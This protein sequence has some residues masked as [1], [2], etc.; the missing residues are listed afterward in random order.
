MLSEKKKVIHSLVFPLFFLIILWLIK[1]V[2]Y[3]LD[4]SFANLGVYP[5]KI[6]GLIGII[7]APLIHS[8]FSH[9]ISNS[10]PILLLSF[11]L[12]YFYRKVAYRVFFLIYFISGLWVWVSARPSFHIGASGIVYG[13]AAFLLLSGILRRN[14]NLMGLSLLIIFLY[15][16]LIWGIFPME[17]KI[18]WESHLMGMIAGIVLAI[19][20]KKEGPQRKRFDWED[21]NEE[22]ENSTQVKNN[23]FNSNNTF[24]IEIEY[25]I[26]ENDN[27]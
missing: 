25:H 26:K 15:G 23:K 11:S 18:S 3:T 24:N 6:K 22:K 13:L 14:I 4:E 5:L 10:T 8:N 17:Q 2:E 1:I 7:T 19:Y 20:Y 21:E 16:S 27:K 9:L 12:F